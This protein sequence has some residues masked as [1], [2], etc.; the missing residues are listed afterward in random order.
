MENRLGRTPLLIA[1]FIWI[2]FA[3]S[4]ELATLWTLLLCFVTA[5][6][7]PA[8]PG[9]TGGMV[10]PQVLLRRGLL[11]ILIFPFLSGALFCH[12]E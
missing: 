11:S 2:T 7:H 6:C 3:G 1:F 9:N 5:W 8:G 4:K 12:L 10:R